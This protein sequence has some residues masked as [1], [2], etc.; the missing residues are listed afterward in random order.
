[1]KFIDAIKRGEK[2]APK[3]RAMLGP[4]MC[5]NA[6]LIGGALRDDDPGDLDVVVDDPD[7]DIF[8]LNFKLS[9]TRFGGAKYRIGDPSENM[10][11]DVWR[12]ADSWCFKNGAG[13]VCIDELL[14]HVH[15]N[16]QA[17]AYHID[18]G[19]YIDAGFANA[20]ETRTI[21]LVWEKNPFP[22]YSLRKAIRVANALNFSHGPKLK[23]VLEQHG[24]ATKNWRHGD[25]VIL[26]S[27]KIDYAHV[28]GLRDLKISSRDAG[29]AIRI[30]V[31][32]HGILID[33]MQTAR[34]ISV[35]T[36]L[37]VRVLTEFGAHWVM[38]S[39]VRKLVEP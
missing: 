3:M 18:T 39:R 5:K 26:E 1:M 37:Y 9:K 10:T 2:W 22:Y 24:L 16:I 8:N 25:R 12:L 33:A 7:I 34:S 38:M 4:E 35:Q 15:T 36:E 11:M 31:G 21:E 19:V 28:Y 20:L 13:S 32:T 14:R 27:D 29:W 17:V 30:P 6:Y 23:A